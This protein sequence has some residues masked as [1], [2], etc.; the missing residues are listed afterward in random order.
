MNRAPSNKQLFG[1]LNAIGELVHEDKILLGAEASE[2]LAT[3]GHY[4][5]KNGIVASLLAA[6][7]VEARGTR[8]TGEMGLISVN[9]P[10]HLF[11]I[12]I[13]TRLGG[14]S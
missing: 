7:A 10:L 12:G 8:L 4:S 11:R 6:K 13:T 3:K 1:L 2:E 14:A 9:R 5:E